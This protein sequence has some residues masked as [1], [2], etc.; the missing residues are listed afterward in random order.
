MGAHDIFFSYLSTW[1][2]SQ[3]IY[4]FGMVLQSNTN[5]ICVDKEQRRER[6]TKQMKFEKKNGASNIL[7]AHSNAAAALAGFGT[8]HF[9]DFHFVVGGHVGTML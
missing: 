7:P 1:Y 4:P 5:K 9:G 3:W 8:M 6:R 2:T